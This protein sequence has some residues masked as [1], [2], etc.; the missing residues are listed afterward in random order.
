MHKVAILSRCI[1]ECIQLKLNNI[2]ELAEGI[3]MTYAF[4]VHW[5]DVSR[6]VF[7]SEG[8]PDLQS[9]MAYLN[10]FAYDPNQVKLECIQIYPEQ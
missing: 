10:N 7:Y 3:M 2:M 4:V 5:V 9:C 8:M 1:T 6:G